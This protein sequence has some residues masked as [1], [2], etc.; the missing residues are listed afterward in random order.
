MQIPEENRIVI[1]LPQLHLR[2]LLN[3]RFFCLMTLLLFASVFVYWYQTIRPWL[4][5]TARV[6]ASST[7]L[8]SD[9]AGRIVEMNANEGDV[10]KKG[11][12]LFV[13][14]RDLLLAKQ[15]QAKL[16]IQALQ[17]QI[18]MEK[19]RIGKAMEDYLVATNELE[20][21]IGS[22]EGIKKHL[23]SMQEAQE[24]TEL[25]NAQLL[26][27]RAELDVIDLQFK[28]MAFS[29][30]F[31]GIVLKCCK[32][33]GS[34]ISFGEPVYVLCNPNQIWIESAVPESEI[35]YISLG[36]L[37]RIQLPAYPGQELTGKVQWI[38]P[39]TLAK[40]LPS[41]PAKETE[42]IPIKISMDPSPISPK[43]GLSAR[44]GLKVR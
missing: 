4:W 26:A 37:A 34:V 22:P 16:A 8:S 18:E 6:E 30:P 11:Q 27:A 1:K 24:K 25:A 12:P 38:G 43:P 19:G 10:V 35:S 31:D 15:T 3:F 28:K 39:A 20:I 5:S 7:I 40:S 32:N 42:L 21:G 9:L 13:L 36:T 14:D 23:A 29:A 17:D 44:V 33:L 41:G 2:S